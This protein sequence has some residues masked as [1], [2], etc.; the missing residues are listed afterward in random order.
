M[1]HSSGSHEPQYIEIAYIFAKILIEHTP[2][3]TLGR[4]PTTKEAL[5]VILKK[6]RSTGKYEVKRNE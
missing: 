1:N 5:E 6:F 4:S 2:N 3:T